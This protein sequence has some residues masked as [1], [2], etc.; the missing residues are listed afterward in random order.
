MF[1][2]FTSGLEPTAAVRQHRGSVTASHSVVT[3][4]VEA[5]HVHLS[6][7]NLPFWSFCYFKWGGETSCRRSLPADSEGVNLPLIASEDLVYLDIGIRQ[8]ARHPFH[9]RH[10]RQAYKIPD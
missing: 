10:P 7:V 9:S 8:R 4:S 2:N 6:S 5:L 3:I 1:P